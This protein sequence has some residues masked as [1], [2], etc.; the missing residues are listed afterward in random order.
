MSEV[1]TGWKNI[2]VFLGIT[3]RRLYEWHKLHPLPISKVGNGRNSK[4]LIIKTDLLAYLR[5]KQFSKIR[6][7]VFL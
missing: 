2:A 4:V 7:D 1:I 3:E 5:T 6:K